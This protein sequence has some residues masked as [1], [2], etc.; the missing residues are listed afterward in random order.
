MKM[1]FIILCVFVLITLTLGI[2]VF[3]YENRIADGMANGDNLAI[4]TG[5]SVYAENCASCHGDTLQGE[6]DWQSPKPDGRMP[7]PPHDDSGHTW[8]HSDQLLFDYTKKGGQA[9]IPGD[10]KSGMPA[11][12]EILTDDEIKSVLMFIKS[13]WSERSQ[14]YQ[15]KLSQDKK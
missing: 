4:A 9:M 5:K 14:A 2:F 1:K 3:Y 8:H 10:F 15:K 7:A 11:F 13:Q 12:D 6:P